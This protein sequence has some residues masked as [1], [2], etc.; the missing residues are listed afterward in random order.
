MLF[1]TLVVSIRSSRPAFSVGISC[2]T[3]TSIYHIINNSSHIII[4]AKREN[5]PFLFFVLFFSSSNPTTT[6]TRG[7]FEKRATRRRHTYICIVKTKREK[8]LIA[9][10]KNLLPLIRRIT[11]T[12]S[13]LEIESVFF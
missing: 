13:P 8:Q 9:N 1:C 7:H 4:T 3:Y 12:R 5:T 11:L 2:C 6:T 10:N